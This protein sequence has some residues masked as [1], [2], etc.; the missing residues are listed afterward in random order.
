MIEVQT[1][2]DRLTIGGSLLHA[3][4]QFVQHDALIYDGR[5]ADYAGLAAEV[6]ARARGLLGF[7]VRPGDHVGILMPNGWDHVILFYA[8]ALIGARVVLLNA[9]YRADDLAFVIPWADLDWLAIGSQAR[10]HADYRTML[11]DVFPA[12]SAWDGQTDLALEEAPRLRKIL[13][14]GDDRAGRWPDATTLDARAADID[15]ATVMHHAASVKPDDVAL[16]M[17]SSGTTARPKCCMLSHRMLADTGA[18]FAVRFEM[19]AADRIFDPLPLFHMSTVLPM[20]AC[21]TVGACFIGM[22]HFEPG[23]AISLLQ[24]ERATI[25]Y[26]AFPTLVAA[27][28]AHPD[29]PAYDQRHLRI[30]HV[31]GPTDLLRRYLGLFPGALPV[32]SYGLTEATG[33][34]CYTPL[35]D[36]PELMLETSGIPFP[37]MAVRIVDAVTGLPVEDG[38]PGEI[39]LKGFCLFAGYYRDEAATRAVMTDDGWLKTGDRGRIHPTGRLVYE[40]RI[41]DML[42]IGG[43]NVA[44]IEIESFLANHPA[45][46]MAQVVGVPDDHLM[47][48]ACAYLEL[49]DGATI[50]AEEVVRFCAGKIASYKIPRYVRFVDTWPMSA[51]KVQ[52][53]LLRQTFEPVDKLDVAAI[54]RAAQA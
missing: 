29:F 30:N 6:T 7:G 46:R 51:T 4:Q 18:A 12:L 53:Y 14:F 45:I 9:R 15:A 33:V 11:T 24:D 40:G 13:N 54:V 16:M 34:P 39:Q 44:A 32:N 8:A 10:E 1:L 3:A 25:A 20:A 38:V 48:V 2:P 21:R 27:V 36:P 41:K 50:T 23:E 31:V 17:F 5:R 22:G 19:S 37:G 35:S 43:E 49:E 42:K 28:V 47:E 52:K 26:M